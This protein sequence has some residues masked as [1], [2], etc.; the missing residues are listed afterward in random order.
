M[1]ARC[2]RCTCKLINKT[3]AKGSSLKTSTS[4][5]SKG[6]FHSWIWRRIY[7]AD[8]VLDRIKLIQ[9]S[10][11][12]SR[13][14]VNNLWRWRKIILERR[15]TITL[16]ISKSICFPFHNTDWFFRIVR[17]RRSS[18]FIASPFSSQLD[19]NLLAVYHSFHRDRSQRVFA[20]HTRS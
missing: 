3:K 17:K 4:L 18:V 20:W 11:D 16:W 2:K 15:P 10:G 5:M 14:P 9:S 7:D 8:F 6:I 19:S 13:Q 1:Q 12:N